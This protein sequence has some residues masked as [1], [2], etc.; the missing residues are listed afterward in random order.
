MDKR[1]L[2]T[3]LGVPNSSKNKT[4]YYIELEASNV[5]NV[6]IFSKSD[7]FIC[8]LRSKNPKIDIRKVKNNEVYLV[9][10]TEYCKNTL[11]P[12]FE[13]FFISSSYLTLDNENLILRIEIWD[14]SKRGKHTKISQ[15][16]FTIDQILNGHKVVNTFNNARDKNYGVIFF[17]SF[18]KYKKPSFEDIQQSM[19]LHLSPVMMIDFCKKNEPVEYESSLHHMRD[20]GKFNDYEKLMIKI[21]RRFSKKKLIFKEKK[22]KFW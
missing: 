9:K 22:K 17:K 15:G 16:Y 5:K 13:P 7:P 6:E 2:T 8:I 3:H 12:K 11:E 20:D 19:N 10:K 14:H 4:H 1:N 18:F 21:K